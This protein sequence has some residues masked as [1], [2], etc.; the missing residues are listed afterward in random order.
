MVGWNGLIGLP[1]RCRPIGFSADSPHWQGLAS[2]SF[3]LI[4]FCLVGPLFPALGKPLQ[5]VVA[6]FGSPNVCCNRIE[7]QTQTWS[8][9]G[10]MSSLPQSLRWDSLGILNTGKQTCPKRC[11][12]KGVRGLP[13]GGPGPGVAQAS[14]CRRHEAPLASRSPYRAPMPMAHETMHATLSFAAREKG[15]E[16]DGYPPVA[17]VAS[18]GWIQMPPLALA[19]RPV[20]SKKKRK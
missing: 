12:V 1:G 17:S 20:A 9:G 7:M 18:V 3:F 6:D 13:V 8:V 5:V 10:W 19:A 4:S 14:V 11:F 15:Y 16:L 2:F